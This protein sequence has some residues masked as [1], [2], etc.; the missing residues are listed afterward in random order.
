[1]ENN[2]IICFRRKDFEDRIKRIDE[3]QEE[4]DNKDSY[5][6]AHI[7]GER[8]TLVNLLSTGFSGEDIFNAAREE[9]FIKHPNIFQDDWE[10]V[11]EKYEDYL[12]TLEK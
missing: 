5:N 2:D 7:E 1:M 4:N 8:L 12:K 11:Y 9:K 3:I 10:V 6:S